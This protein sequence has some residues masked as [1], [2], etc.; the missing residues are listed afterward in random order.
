MEG[1]HRV[2]ARSLLQAF[3]E[4]GHSCEILT[5]PQNRFGRQFSAYL[6]TRLTDVELT[7][8]GE[9]IDRLVSLRFPSYLLKHPQH[10]CWLNHRMREYYDLWPT[11]SSQL[12][13]NGKFKENI[14]RRLIHAADRYFLKKNVRKLFAQSK[15]IQKGLLQWGNIPSVVLYPP[16]PQRNYRTEEYGDFILS[17]SRLTPLKRVPMLIEALANTKNVRTVIAGDGDERKRIEALIEK[18]GLKERVQMIGQ[19]SDD[20]L[21]E[22]YSRCRAVYYAPSNEDFGLVT[23]EAFA[24]AKP[25]ITATDSGGPTELVQ[26]QIN[27]FVVLPDAA[28][29]ARVITSLLD[30]PP[31]AEKLG[32]AAYDFA[33]TITWPETVKR[34]LD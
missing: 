15:N 28:E 16:P 24:C 8:N 25:V 23:M 34:L 7:G 27:G 5:T 33:K 2:I 19:V 6:A 13:T 26:D 21:V 30:E 9:R 1:G 10:I 11:W 3:Q 4:S 31:L 29:I 17:P 12:S 14:R 20:R 32:T 18:H 22:L